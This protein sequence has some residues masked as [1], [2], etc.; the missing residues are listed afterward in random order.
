MPSSRSRLAF[1]KCWVGEEQDVGDVEEPVGCD[2]RF[3]RSRVLIDAS[4]DDA[5]DEDES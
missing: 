5:G 3:D 4:V 2:A 1:N